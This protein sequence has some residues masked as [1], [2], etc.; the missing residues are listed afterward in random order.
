[1]SIS[2]SLKLHIKCNFHNYVNLLLV[3]IIG[4][5]IFMLF[6]SD[7]P[8]YDGDAGC[9]WQRRWK[10]NRIDTALGEKVYSAVRIAL[11]ELVEHNPSADQKFRMVSL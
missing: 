6:I 4:A 7:A 9:D 8:I 1:M 2:L 5:V 10:T 11:L 3:L